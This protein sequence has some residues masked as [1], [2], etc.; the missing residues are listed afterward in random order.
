M[1]LGLILYLI[2]IFVILLVT[3]IVGNK[4]GILLAFLL[5]VCG[6]C[7]LFYSEIYKDWLETIHLQIVKRKNF[8][9]IE[10]LKK[11]RCEIIVQMD[12]GDVN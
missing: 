4:L 7:C 2:Y 3:F 11:M 12:C 10:E 1:G 6:Y 5:P 8:A 9:F